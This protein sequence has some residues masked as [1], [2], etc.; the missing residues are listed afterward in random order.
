M[1]FA[2]KTRKKEPPLSVEEIKV[3]GWIEAVIEDGEDR[4][5]V[6]GH[7]L[8]VNA[9]RVVMLVADASSHDPELTGIQA[10]DVLTLNLDDVHKSEF[11][12]EEMQTETN[13]LT[14]EFASML[15][16]QHKDEFAR[17][18]PEFS[19]ENSERV[20]ELDARAIGDYLGRLLRARQEFAERLISEG[21]ADSESL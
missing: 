1:S 15:V 12:N 20:S 6:L 17:R 18:Y 19:A 16:R 8:E 14:L 13:L 4:N 2:G 5:V 21:R 10:G 11:S 7:A 3:H 9:G